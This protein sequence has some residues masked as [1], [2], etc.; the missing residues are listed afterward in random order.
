MPTMTTRPIVD[1]PVLDATLHVAFDLG[2]TEWTLASTPAVAEAPRVRTMPTRDLARLVVEF[3]TARRHFGLSN[4]APIR[5][6]YEAG[7]DGFWL[8]RALASAG[9]PNVIVD[10]ASIEV[11]RRARQ[12]KTDRLDATALLRLLLRYA[13]GETH[14]WRV[15]LIFETME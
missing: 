1:D 2:N 8:H 11:S 4:A 15:A 12:A 13:A 6:C 9:I 5:T 3:E 10:S 14:V 7:R